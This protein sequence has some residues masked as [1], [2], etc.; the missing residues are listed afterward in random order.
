MRYNNKYMSFLKGLFKKEEAKANSL[1]NVKSP[2]GSLVFEFSLKNGSPSYR[3]LKNQEVLLSNSR[4]GFEIYNE[5]PIA[6]NLGGGEDF[7][8][9]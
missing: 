4:L 1:V 5:K 2:S 8:K 3:V 9:I 6:E 7:A